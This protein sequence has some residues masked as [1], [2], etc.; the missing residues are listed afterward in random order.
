MGFTSNDMDK[1]RK[2][3]NDVLRGYGVRENIKFEIG[4]ITYDDNSFRATLKAFNTAHGRDPLKSEFEKYCYKFNIPSDWY[5]KIVE[6]KGIHYKV[7][8]IKPRARKYPVLLT[9]ANGLAKSVV[10]SSDYLRTL[11]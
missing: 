11:V 6:I 9:P 7:S 2:D 4:R 10:V 5:G 8:A 1:M 3:I